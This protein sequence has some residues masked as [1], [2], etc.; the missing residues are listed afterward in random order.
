MKETLNFEGERTSETV[1]TIDG[2]SGAGKGTVAGHI[3]EV[4]NIEH[5]S[6]GDFFR[7]IASERDLTVGELSEK[8]DKE[9]DLE[10]D[11]RTFQKGLSENCVIESRIS[12]HVMGDYS[13]LKIRLTADLDERGDRVAEREEI[14]EEE[15]RERIIKRDR[16]NKE[17]YRDY[18]GID[19]DNFQIYDLIIDNTELSIEET[20]ELVETALEMWFEDV[21]N[22]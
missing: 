2:R 9:T 5:Y 21:Q 13:D 14:S 17:R 7:N 3:S 18:Y 19:M 22:T 8:A 1:I 6:A 11:R 4:M 20:N 10:V 12:C 16:D 15:A